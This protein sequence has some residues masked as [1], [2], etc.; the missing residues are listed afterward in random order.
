VEHSEA[1]QCLQCGRV[2]LKPRKGSTEAQWALQQFCKGSCSGKWL[3]AQRKRFDTGEETRTVDPPPIIFS[4]QKKAAISEC[5]RCGSSSIY[6]AG[7]GIGCR[8]CGHLMFTR[9][10]NWEQ[11]SR[12]ATG[13]TGPGE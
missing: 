3:K 6:D 11:E 2:I 13:S 7:V 5:L 10:G 8:P 4:A 1:P 12:L 9:D